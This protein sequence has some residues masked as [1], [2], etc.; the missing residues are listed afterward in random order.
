VKIGIDFGTTRIVVAVADRG[1]YPLVNFETPEGEVRDWFPSL[2]AIN[3][4]KRI[5]GWEAQERHAT[6]GW[7]LVRSLK[8]WLK[9]AGPQTELK[10]AGQRLKLSQVLTEMMAALR[11]EL[12]ERS[13][14]GAGKHDRLQI[15]LGVPANANSNQRFLTQEAACAAGFEVLG[16]LNEP[17]AAA[18]EYAYRNNSDRKRR[19]KSALLVYDLGGG[20]F[21]VSLVALDENEHTVIASD[22][23]PN[24]GGDDF[25]EILGRLALAKAH[26][27]AAHEESLTPAEWYLLFDEC[28]EKKESL[29]ANS[30]RLAVDLERVRKDWGEVSIPAEAFYEQCRPLVESSRKVV[31]DL[32]AAH[33]GHE[34]DTLY[35]TGGGSELP[36]VAR[37]L[38]E[39]FG[40]KVRRSAYM[41]SATAIG[42]T[43]RA[44][45]QEA[46]PFRDQFTKH[47]GVWRE[48]NEGNNVVFDVIFPRGLRLPSRGEAP[49]QIARSYHPVHNIGYFRYLECAH[50]DVDNQPEGEITNW[51]EIR[52]AF[53]PKLA[54]L[55]NLT[56]Q[57]VRRDSAL[58]DLWVEEVYTCD[59][60][61]N[62]RV[63][64]YN[65]TAEQTHEYRLGRWSKELASRAARKTTA[66][67]N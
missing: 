61:G 24:F 44:E 49:L 42:L 58:L 14:L 40:R 2:L 31:E 30:R 16:L 46:R 38:R 50:L 7:T 63:K 26:R 23:I 53:D 33:P 19:S 8:R 51:D 15:M 18:V 56:E 28:R 27:P 37:V 62:V 66:T 67:S 47:F 17:S 6:P 52:V 55:T 45:G 32:L 3:G 64:I 4:E 10:I 29:N 41:R 59:A 20:T 5:Y 25:D 21:D 9:N 11:R 34:I 1:N 36:S 60:N 12:M 43:I 22:G 48:A 57:T 39:S 13:T 35:L 65:P 54:K